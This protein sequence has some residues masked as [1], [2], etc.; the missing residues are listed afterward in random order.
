VAAV[1][2]GRAVCYLGSGCGMVGVVIVKL[3]LEA[4]GWRSRRLRSVVSLP[5]SLLILSS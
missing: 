1:W 4:E 3:E 5:Y 2:F